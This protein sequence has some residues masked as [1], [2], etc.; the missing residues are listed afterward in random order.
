ML[1]VWFPFLI[2]S[3]AFAIAAQIVAFLALLAID[4]RLLVIGVIETHYF[5]TRTAVTAIATVSLL[6]ILIAQ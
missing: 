3:I 5:R 1:G 2:A 6:T 4:Y